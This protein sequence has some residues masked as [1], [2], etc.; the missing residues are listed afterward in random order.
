MILFYFDFRTLRKLLDDKQQDWDL[1]LEGA[2][3]AINTNTSKTTKY[4]PFFLMYGRNPRFPFEA[5]IEGATTEASPD[6]DIE[7]IQNH[8]EQICKMQGE[9]YPVVAE[10]IK[11]AQEKQKIQYQIKKA[12]TCGRIESGSQVLKRNMLQK[13]KKGHKME[14]NWLGPYIVCDL[15]NE[16]GT[17]RLKDKFGKTLK[18]QVPLK[19]LKLY[20]EPSTSQPPQDKAQ[21]TMSMPSTSQP[22]KDKAQETMSM[23]S[24]IQ[25]PQENVSVN[26]MQNIIKGLSE[27]EFKEYIKSTIPALQNI[28]D[29]VLMNWRYDLVMKGHC[30]EYPYLKLHD[31]PY[32]IPLSGVDMISAL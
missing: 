9:L 31:L 28:L 21:V 14:D 32:N 15:N 19:Q 16:K 17:S 11:S 25:P 8:V 23:L 3:F 30:K 27:K 12:P 29:G 22:P 4:S 7:S 5:E 20:Q 24:T 6:A 1:Y 2:L 13:T 26:D 10:N 18:R